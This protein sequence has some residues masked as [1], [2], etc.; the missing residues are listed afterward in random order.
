M[1]HR[2]K[3]LHTAVIDIP[4][5]GADDDHLH[6]L[7]IVLGCL[8]AADQIGAEGLGGAVGG[9]GGGIGQVADLG[10]EQEQECGAGAGG[11]ADPADVLH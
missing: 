3:L 10:A 4:G 8:H 11:N 7:L 5:E 9:G 1:L 2:G 6:V